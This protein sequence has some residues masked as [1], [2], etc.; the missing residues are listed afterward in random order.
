MSI[1]PLRQIINGSLLSGVVVIGSLLVSCSQLSPSASESLSFEAQL[2]NHLTAEG[3]KMYGAYW[4]PHCADQKERFGDAVDRVPYIE[5][6]PSGEAA[7]PEVCQAKE[8]EGYP[9]WEINGQLYPGVRSL[10]ELAE[11]SEFEP[12]PE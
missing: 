12:S 2:A 6:D 1:F 4:C 10:E 7:Q 5:C 8:L 9:T 11:L 3:D